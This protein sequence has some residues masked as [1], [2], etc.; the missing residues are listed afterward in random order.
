M[1]LGLTDRSPSS[2]APAA[3]SGWRSPGSRRREGARGRRLARDHRGVAGACRRRHGASRRPS[4]SRP[5]TARPAGRAA[6]ERV[7]VLV[8]NVLA[9]AAPAA[10]RFLAITDEMWQRTLNL[11]LMAAVRTMRAAHPGDARRRRRRD[12]QHRLGQ[13]AAAGPGRA[14]LLGGQGGA[15]QRGQVAVEGVRRPRASGSTTST[16]DRS[17]PTSG[18]AR[19]GSPHGS[20]RRAGSDPRTSPPRPPPGWS[21]AGSPGPRRSPTWCFPG[22]RAGGKRHRRRLRH[23]RRHGDHASEVVSARS[24]PASR[25][26]RRR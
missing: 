18:S 22:Q 16:R 24:W 21:P 2:P 12:R 3:A 25:S 4:T 19:T 13:R 5:P 9:G 10:R 14:R 20:A 15:G 11:D 7:D 6:G 17:P 8:N 23:R 26:V 1:E